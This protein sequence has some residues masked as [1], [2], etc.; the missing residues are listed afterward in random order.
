MQATGLA[1][2]AYLE[3]F[4]ERSADSLTRGDPA[5]YDKRVTTTWSLAF[6]QVEHDA[7]RVAGLLACCAPD[8]VPLGLLLRPRPE[9]AESLAPE[10]RPVLAPLLDDPLEVSD[11]IAALRRC[12]LVGVPVDGAVL[13][14]RLVQA[15]TLAQPPADAAAA[16]KEA[17]AALVEAAIPEHPRQPTEWP[18]FAV[19]LPHAQAALAA[20]STGMDRIASYLR[21]SGSYAAARSLYRQIA[22]AREEALGAEDPD[23]LFARTSIA[24][25]AAR[26]GNA[27]GARDQLAAL[28]PICERVLGPEHLTTLTTRH[29]LARST[30]EAGDAAVARDQLA[31]LLPVRERVS[32]AEHAST[33]SVSGSSAVRPRRS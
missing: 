2:T 13:V 30:G 4:R 9:L 16:W 20:H 6:S 15:V 29:D 32:G 11:A 3:L 5:G 26:E 25:L 24:T 28:L 7:P 1:M 10:V 18:V 17:A 8:Q 33:R 22:E 27:A 14:H 21:H 23:T 12:S 19:L 31:M